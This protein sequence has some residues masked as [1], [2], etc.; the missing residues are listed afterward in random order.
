MILDKEDYVIYQC[1]EC[2]RSYQV[3][4]KYISRLTDPSALNHFKG[5]FFVYCAAADYGVEIESPKP[6]PTGLTYSQRQWEDYLFEQHVKLLHN[7]LRIAALKVF[8]ILLKATQSLRKSP[9]LFEPYKK[10]KRIKW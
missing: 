6:F 9:C 4:I 3:D 10:P 1:K 2:E 7:R 8:R 5:M